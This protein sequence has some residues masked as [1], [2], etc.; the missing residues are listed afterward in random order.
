M[1]LDTNKINKKLL[2]ILLAI[3]VALN[4]FLCLIATSVLP[5]FADLLAEQGQSS[6]YNSPEIYIKLSELFP[7]LSN[8]EVLIQIPFLDIYPFFFVP[9]LISLLYAIF[10]FV[11]GKGKPDAW[12]KY[13]C[14][15]I[16]GT[17]GIV[18]ITIFTLYMPM[19]KY[20]I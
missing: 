11:Y 15:V 14:I 8:S 10:F 18:L 19:F 5:T 6:I 9:F 12:V 4:I 2:F 7:S 1:Q 3:I 20:S 16:F 13:C 17:I